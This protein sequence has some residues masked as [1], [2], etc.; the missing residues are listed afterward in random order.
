MNIPEFS[1]RNF[2]TVSRVTTGLV[3][4][5]AAV[6]VY[7]MIFRSGWEIKPQWN[8]FKSVLLSPLYVIGLII[9]LLNMGRNH[10]SYDV[11]EEV[12]HADGSKDRHKS[13][14]VTDVVEGGCLAPL[15]GHFVIEPL[16]Y[17]AL[18]YYPLMGIVALLGQFVPYV[19]SVIVIALCYLVY[20]TDAWFAFRGRSI[21]LV[22]LALM[23]TVGFAFGAASILKANPSTPGGTTAKPATGGTITTDENG[24]SSLDGVPFVDGNDLAVFELQGPVRSCTWTRGE[25]A[26][27]T[28]GFDRNGHWATL[29]GEA[30]EAA[31]VSDV[32]RIEG[33]GRLRKY[34]IGEYDAADTYTYEFASTG[35]PSTQ[36]IDSADGSYDLTTYTYDSRGFVTQTHR[37]GTVIEMGADEGDGERYD[38]TYTYTYSDGDIDSHGNWTKRQCTGTDGNKWTEVRS[39]S[40]Y[41]E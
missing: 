5:A 41:S 7:A 11:V 8:M 23:L 24:K 15:L 25:S 2:R 30:L 38:A 18:I 22:V 6:L 21:A 3:A 13:Q 9:A 36:R 19:L 29:G 20:K 31:G 34:T 17:A 35:Q 26:P 1:P 14:D 16:L 37:Q 39:M 4:V 28:Y 12:T 32:E 10:Y 27:Q 40:Y 33:G